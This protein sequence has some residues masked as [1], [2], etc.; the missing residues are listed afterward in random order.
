MNSSTFLLA[1]LGLPIM[2]F[3]FHYLGK[4]LFGDGTH[5]AIV[6]MLLIVVIGSIAAIFVPK[7]NT[8]SNE[9]GPDYSHSYY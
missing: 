5:G 2:V 6:V 7:S 8:V 9:A 3:V 1:F 4:K